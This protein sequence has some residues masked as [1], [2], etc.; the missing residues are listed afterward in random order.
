MESTWA[1]LVSRI[2]PLSVSEACKII[3]QA[4]AGLEHLRRHHLVH[5]D[6]KPS[7]LMLTRDGVVKIVDMGLALLRDEQSQRLTMAG[8]AMGSVDYIAPEQW[9]DSHE[10]DW[11]SDVYSLGCAFY[12]LLAGCAPFSDRSKTS[13][14]KMRAHLEDRI[15]DIRHRRAD[16]PDDAAELLE[17]MVRK[18]PDERLTDLVEI[19]RK[20]ELIASGDL[21]GLVD[22]GFEKL[23]GKKKAKV[24]RNVFRPAERPPAAD[25]DIEETQPS[26][27]IAQSLETNQRPESPESPESPAAS[28]TPLSLRPVAWIGVI[29]LTCVGLLL[30]IQAWNSRGGNQPVPLVS[31]EPTAS[32]NEIART[33][34]PAVPTPSPV[35][36][37]EPIECIG[38]ASKVMGVAFLSESK[39]ASVDEEGA[40]CIFDLAD[41]GQPL[42]RVSVSSRAAAS[43]VHD[44]ASGTL[45][46]GCEDGSLQVRSDADGSSLRSERI[47]GAGLSSAV[48]VPG[49]ETVVTADWEGHVRL[50]D[51]AT[52][53]TSNEILGGRE[54]V[55]YDVC[56]SPDGQK[57]AWVGRAPEVTV[58]QFSDQT[59]TDFTDPRT[60]DLPAPG[61]WVYA[62]AISP[63][64]GRLASAGHDDS[65]RIWRMDSGDLETVLGSTVPQAIA[66]LPDSRHLAVGGRGTVLEIWDLDKSRVVE[67]FRVDASIDCVAV[68]PEAKRVAAGAASGR[69]RVWPLRLTP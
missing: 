47:A 63:D 32:E 21:K 20:L 65:V 59:T 10:V 45:L 62:V 4:A 36:T 16:V 50:I 51:L 66:F 31:S 40:L 58:F 30:G 18:N 1:S 41:P 34:D 19:S 25:L 46:I 13:V 15:P 39:L 23:E 14:S 9:R 5:R 24:F 27:R 22:R 52:K 7:N 42:H 26:H 6:I 12:C 11:R 67:E 2:G 37:A 35:A 38:H 68:S 17:S 44:A 56:V 3:S 57:L 33:P 53:P 54:Q 61:R 48:R 28:A 60:I 43:I 69:L 64:G 55:I 49:S 8:E 29:A